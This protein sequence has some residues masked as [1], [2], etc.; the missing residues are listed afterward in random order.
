MKLI[1]DFENKQ[2]SFIAGFVHNL[3]ENTFTC[4]FFLF[5]YILTYIARYEKIGLVFFLIFSFSI[6]NL[7]KFYALVVYSLADRNNKSFSRFDF[8]SMISL[9]LF[10]SSIIYVGSIKFNIFPVTN[11]SIGTLYLCIMFTITAFIGNVILPYNLGHQKISFTTKK[12]E[13]SA[14]RFYID[15]KKFNL[16]R[17]IMVVVPVVIVTLALRYVLLQL[18]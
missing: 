10:I 18:N 17:V 3:F 7:S 13:I 8:G 6:I 14:N 11:Q 16:I 12:D 4:A 15:K 2:D 1:F 9:L 5:V